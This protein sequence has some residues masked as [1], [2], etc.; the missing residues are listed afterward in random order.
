MTP[1]TSCHRS[2][3]TIAIATPVTIA[4]SPR[5]TDARD[6]NRARELATEMAAGPAM[7]DVVKLITAPGRGLS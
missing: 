2:P 6:R 5:A 4:M 3:H 1:L 7:A